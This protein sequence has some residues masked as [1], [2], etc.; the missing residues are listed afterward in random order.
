MRFPHLFTTALLLAPAV[1]FAQLPDPD[2]ILISNRP[3]PK[4][5]LVGTFEL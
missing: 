5:L 4:V 3:R 1:A 2:S